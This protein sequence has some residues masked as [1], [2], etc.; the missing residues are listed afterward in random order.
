M[1]P[2]GAIRQHAAA[3]SYSWD[4]GARGRFARPQNQGGSALPSSPVCGA[5]V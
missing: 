5:A 1:G 3:E 4:R 2:G